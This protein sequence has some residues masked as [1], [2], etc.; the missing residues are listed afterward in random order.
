[1]ASRKQT[2]LIYLIQIAGLGILG[3]IVGTIAGIFLQQFFPLLL[4]DFLPFSVELGL[5][6]KPILMGLLLGVL[7]S[8]LFALLPLLNTWFVSPLQV[9]RFQ[10]GTPV[11][12]RRIVTIVVFVILLFI[13]GFAQWLL[14]NWWYALYFVAS[15]L[16]VF[17]VLFGL[18]YVLM[19]A[20][21]R[22]FPGSWGF[23]AR[24]SL[25]NLFRPNNQTLVL[26]LAIGV[27]AFL[28]STLYFSKDILLAK[29]TV[30]DNGESP[31]II[32]LD[33]QTGQKDS[34]AQRILPKGLPVIDDI[35]IVTMRVHSIKGRAVNEL[36]KDTVLNM[37]KWILNHEFRV[38][39]RDSLI[40]SEVLTDGEWIAS[41]DSKS[42]VPISVADFIARDG[43]VGIG[44]TI[45]FNVQGVLMKTF[46]SSIRTVDWGRMQPN[47]SILFPKG[48]LE[49]APQ[50]HVMTTRVPDTKVSADLQRDLIRRFPNVSILDL[51]QLLGILE[52]ILDKISW[53]INFMAFFSILTGIIVLMGSVKTSKYQRIRENVLL[54]TLGAK[55]PQIL[56]ITAFEYVYL[57]FLGTLIGVLLS[58]FAA[59]LLARFVFQVPFVP[60]W[61]PFLVLLPG[62]PI[63][64][65]LIGLGNS[66][67][68]VQSPPLQVLRKE[69]G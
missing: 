5:S 23:T 29:A 9:L 69:G 40:D 67:G 48:V 13:L 19:W 8:V 24:Q 30:G 21:K 36:R 39:Y 11:R 10:E 38:T 62:I 56:R 31:N 55:S 68:V 37:N 6:I 41:S 14:D 66:R 53:V 34:I 35:P 49:N 18:A 22:Y 65:L 43:K 28:I 57:G 44:D 59:Q 47:F 12:S 45:S 17:S 16:V 3:G 63:L 64:V 54:R 61:V 2:F 1:G 50:F 51:R 20:A 60:S 32:L 46:V 58:F 52:G 15:V 4:G 25:L 26:I 27:G 7:I 33:V 42:V